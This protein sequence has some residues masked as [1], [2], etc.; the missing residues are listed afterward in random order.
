MLTVTLLRHAKSSRDD[1]RLA[2]ID[3]PL[4]ERGRRD[5]P[6]MAAWMKAQGIAP[7]LVVCSTSVRTRET[8]KGVATALTAGVQTRFEPALYHAQDAVLLQ[9]I[10]ALPR[11]ATHALLIGHNPGFHD[12]ALSLAGAGPRDLRQALAEKFPSCGCAVLT[13]DVAA[14]TDVAAARGTLMHWMSPKRLR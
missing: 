2:D 9:V 1:P 10:Q 12:C 13:F 7:D 11:Q 4:A 3:R 14:W 8:W 6:R 5:A